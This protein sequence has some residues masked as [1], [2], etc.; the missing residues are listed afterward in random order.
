M[1][2]WWSLTYLGLVF[3]IGGLAISSVV[4]AK[5]SDDSLE[6]YFEDQE[7]EPENHERA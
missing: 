5:Q 2:G 4:L 6:Q 1:V 3:L 7:R